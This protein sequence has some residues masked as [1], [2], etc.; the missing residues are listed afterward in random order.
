MKQTLQPTIAV[1]P[2][3]GAQFTCD[4]LPTSS[5]AAVMAEWRALEQTLASTSMASS[6]DWTDAWLNNYG[7]N[8]PHEFLRLR[9]DDQTI[10][11][12]LLTHSVEAK[13]AGINVRRRHLG[14]AGEADQQSVCVEFNRLLVDAAH[15]G[16]FCAEIVRHLNADSRWDEFCL[17]G[18]APADVDSLISLLPGVEIWSRPSKFAN[19]K[20]IRESDDAEILKHLGRSTRSNLRR[21]LRDYGDLQ[22]EWAD[23]LDDAQ[24]IH[25]ELVR[26]HQVRWAQQ[27]E[28]GAYASASFAAFQQELITRLHPQGRIVLFRVR[29]EGT[30]VG[31]LQLLVD[32]NRL[33]DYTSGFVC[34]DEKPS[35]GLVTHYLCMQEALARG[36]DAYDFLV[37]DKQ[38]KTN[39]STD[40]GELLWLRYARSSLK[41]QLL[42][43][44]KN[45]KRRPLR[46][47]ES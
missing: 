19:L 18:F 37:G 17:D 20:T 3:R 29:H 16:R 40:T 30:T 35:P 46:N 27:G 13:V 9:V 4:V 23:S 14:T 32:H 25:A 15:R 31:C 10:G 47:D 12:C 39:L 8:V 28:P 5:R 6:F 41:N 44:L 33:L 34:F 11:L 43:K 21:K 2:R 42:R 36:F 7:N 1:P 24:H 38:H 45:W 22:V 26:L